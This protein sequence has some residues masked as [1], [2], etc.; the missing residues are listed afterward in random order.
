MR[1]E[2][3]VSVNLQQLFELPDCDALALPKPQPLKVR[4]PN[5]G[6]FTAIADLSRGIP[7]DCSLSANLLLQIA[8]FLASIECL[9]KVL[10]VIKP[11]TTLLQALVPPNPVKALEVLPDFLKAVDGLKDCLLMIVPGGQI[12]GFLKDLLLLIIKLIKCL[13]GQLKTILAI[14]QGIELKIGEAEALGN[15]EL[16]RALTC[17]KKNAQRSA[18]HSQQSMEPVINVIG[19]VQPFLEIAGIELAIPGLGS[20]EDSA[21]LAQTIQKL[22]DVVTNIESILETLP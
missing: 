17:A 5:G 11:L 12:F 9:L 3:P 10:G 6:T 8:P 7:N 20:A 22:E 15:T 2:I 4:L 13:I 18:E 21:A 16:V 14:M 1:R 19:L